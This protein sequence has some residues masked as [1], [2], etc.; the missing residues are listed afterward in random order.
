VINKI[1]KPPVRCGQCLHKDCR[2]TDD[3]KPCLGSIKVNDFHTEMYLV[4]P[5]FHIS[6]SD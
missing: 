3:D 1:T 6:C 5:I 2:D 4:L